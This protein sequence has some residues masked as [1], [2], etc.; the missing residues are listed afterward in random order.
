MPKTPKE[1][2]AGESVPPENQPEGTDSWENDQK[3]HEYYYDDAHGY[4]VFEDDK[5]DNDEN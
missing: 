5:A 1:Q 4:E 3:Q 2:Q